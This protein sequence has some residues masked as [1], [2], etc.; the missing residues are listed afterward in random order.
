MLARASLHWAVPDVAPTGAGEHHVPPHVIETRPTRP[1]WAARGFE[2]WTRIE[3]R[4]SKRWISISVLLVFGLVVVL[5]TLIVLP[6]DD[7]G[8][9]TEVESTVFRARYLF[10]GYPFW[11]PFIGLGVPHPLSENLTFHPILVLFRLT[12]PGVALTVFYLAQIWIGILSI[13]AVCRQLGLRA[14]IAILCAV[15]FAL[16]ST[17]VTYLHDFW[18]APLLE[19]TLFPLLLLLVLKLLDSEQRLH[20]LGYSVSGGLCAGLILLNGH[21]GDYPYLAIGMVA[22]LAGRLPRLRA[23]WPWIGV[24]LL[25]LALVGATKVYDLG[26]EAVRG[27]AERTQQIYSMDFWRLLF[28]PISSPFGVEIPNSGSDRLI[29]LGGPFVLLTIAGLVL[30]RKVRHRHVNG[31]RVAVV[32]CFVCWFVT[33]PVVSGTWLSRDPLILFS[34]LLAGLALETLWKTLPRYRPALVLAAVLQVAAMVAGFVPYYRADLVRGVHY[35]RGDTTPSLRNVMKNQDLYVYFEQQPDRSSTRVYMAPKAQDRLYRSLETLVGHNEADHTDYEFTGWS[36]HRLRLVNG[37]FKGTDLTELMPPDSRLVSRLLA[38]PTLPRAARA[39]DVLD[40]GVRPGDPGR[41]CLALPGPAADVPCP[42]RRHHPRLPKPRPLARCDRARPRSEADRDAAESGRLHDSRPHVRGLL[43]RQVTRAAGSGRQ[44]DVGRHEPRCSARRVVAALRVDALAALPDRLAGPPL[45]RSNRAR[46]PAVRRPHR[47]RSSSGHPVG[48][49]RLPS[50]GQDG[51]RVHR[52]GDDL[53]QPAA[54]RVDRGTGSAR[55]T[56]TTPEPSPDA[57]ERYDAERQQGVA[58][59]AGLESVWGWSGPAGRSRA[60]RRA[61]YLIEAAGLRPGVRCLELGSGT[62]E[63]TVRLI[64]SGCDLVAVELSEA[65]AALCR[66][67]VGERAEVVIG[68]IETAEGLEG[69]EFDAIVGVSVLHHVDL[70]LCLDSTF[71]LLRPGGRFAFSEPNMAN[72]QV[73]MERH[74]A[75]VARRRHVTP[76]E[77]A[78]RPNSLRSEF[79]RAGLVVDQCEPFDFVHPATPASLL[80]MVELLGGALEST[81]LVQIAGSIKLAGRRPGAPGG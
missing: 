61:A 43:G 67:R 6:P 55:G 27:N 34:I 54:D 31:L 15:T 44:G 13:W 72:P 38:D 78:F 79:E 26:L 50:L 8:L 25:V 32:V 2:A 36:L 28:Y 22:F 5:P 7:E 21:A 47:L 63:F 49:D 30:V 20:R 1:I 45:G 58:I 42:G 16:S 81:P 70:G 39:L 41:S 64:E 40:I 62:G 24:A 65:T 9:F 57:A 3:E 19:W 12:S 37:V 48:Q 35:L 29:A 76:H 46:V 18:P 51:A 80:G 71:G 74:V 14:W 56:V 10:S 68:N 66:D 17:T 52:L 33:I 60:A 73:W 59:A 69:R 4:L 53:S 23:V 75:L 11:N 77:T